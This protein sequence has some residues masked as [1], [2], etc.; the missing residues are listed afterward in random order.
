MNFRLNFSAH[1]H[2]HKDRNQSSER[3]CPECIKGSTLYPGFCGTHLPLKKIPRMSEP[4]V[5]RQAVIRHPGFQSDHVWPLHWN[6][7]IKGKTS[8]HKNTHRHN[9]LS[10]Q[11]AQAAT[12]PAVQLVNTALNLNLFLAYIKHQLPGL[13][14]N[15]WPKDEETRGRLKM[16][17]SRGIHFKTVIWTEVSY[18][19]LLDCGKWLK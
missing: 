2:A 12:D 8:L 6:L 16:S 3:V 7:Q 15:K 18:F 4:A 17:K 19:K 10:C 13:T 5:P 14:F 9:L 1:T 11:Y